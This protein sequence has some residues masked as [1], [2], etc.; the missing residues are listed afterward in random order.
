MESNPYAQA[1][2]DSIDYHF[3]K[4]PVNAGKPT[5]LLWSLLSREVIYASHATNV[6][7][8]LPLYSE[9]LYDHL[10]LSEIN[11]PRVLNRNCS[12]RFEEV[13]STLKISTYFEETSDVSTT[14]IGKLCPTGK[15]SEFEN[16]IFVNSSCTSWGA[17]IDKTLMR[18]VFDMGASKHYMPK[19]F[20]M[21]NTGLHTLPKFSTTSKGIIV[22]NG[23]LVPVMFIIPVTCSIQD[24]VFKI[25]T[26]VADIHEGI[27]L[28]FGLRNMT[29]IEGEISTKTGSF[30]FLNRSI[31]IYPKEN[32]EV[33]TWAK[34][35]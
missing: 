25:F 13:Q 22:G 31:A 17:L 2:Y 29:E 1:L 21:V 14:Y 34:H 20:Y 4:D 19:S 18:V 24:H 35:T 26:M 28:V 12:N 23:Q 9:R 16:Q 27:D 6:S 32:L 30:R 11:N 33:P 15:N 7:P 8:Y 3:C 10:D 5:E